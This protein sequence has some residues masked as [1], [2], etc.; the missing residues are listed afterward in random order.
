MITKK[1]IIITA[2]ILGAIGAGSSVVWI[3]PQNR[4][5][6]VVVTDFG[7]EL[8]SVK[9]RH[10]LIMQSMDSNLKSMLNNT[11]SPDDFVASAQTSS[12]QV[13]S[14]TTELIESNP[15]GQW[16]GSYFNYAEALKKYN[17]YLAESIALAD[18]VKSGISQADLSGETAKLA[19]MLNETNSYISRSDETRP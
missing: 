16:R 7:G 3:F 10:L 15:P 13:T 4:G 19:S 2:I 14:L 6:S 8:Q 5:Q 18:K 12:S 9:D 17:D 1:G 11:I